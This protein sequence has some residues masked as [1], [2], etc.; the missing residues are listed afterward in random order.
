[1]NIFKL[2]NKNNIESSAAE[3]DDNSLQTLPSNEE[4]VREILCGII[5]PELGINIIDLGL[6]Y[7]MKVN[8]GDVYVKMTM[9]TPG[10]P[11]H[12]SIVGAVDRVLKMH[13]PTKQVNVDLVWEPR[14]TPERLSEAAKE[15]LG[16]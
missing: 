6:V 4:V 9:T 16:F 12:E 5:D 8:D 7:E 14:W 2:M 10:C 1:M 15:K 11:L 13:F 3:I